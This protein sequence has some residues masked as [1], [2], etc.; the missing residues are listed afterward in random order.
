MLDKT[1]GFTVLDL[2]M[3]LVNNA[4]RVEEKKI[5]LTYPNWDIVFFFFRMTLFFRFTFLTL[6]SE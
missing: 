2:V 1:N 4:V 3:I 5:Q 6:I